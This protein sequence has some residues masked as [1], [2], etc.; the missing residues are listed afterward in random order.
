MLSPADN[1]P[2]DLEQE[3]A[4]RGFLRMVDDLG[5]STERFFSRLYRGLMRKQQGSHGERDP[6]SEQIA[7]LRRE[8]RDLM[9]RI[10][11]MQTA[12]SRLKAVFERISEGVIMQS[13]EGRI[14]LMNDAATKLLGSI[15]AFWDSELGRMFRRVQDA[16]PLA[17]GEEVTPLGEPM[18]VQINDRILGATIAA[19]SAP[20]G[21]PLGTLIVLRDVTREA[22]ADRIKD[23]FVTQITHELRTPL[24]SIKGMSDVLLNAP[25]DKPANRKF[26]EAIARNAAVLDRMIVELLDL[27][28]ISAGSFSIR[29]ESLRLDLLVHDTVK[30]REA[31]IKKSSLQVGVMVADS[32]DLTINGDAQ[33]LLW[34][35]G[36][37]L[38]NAL[39]YTLR[40]GSISIRVGR[41]KKDHVLIEVIDSG[42]GISEYDQAHVFERFYR[43]Q[44][45]TTD[46]KTLDPRGLGQGL[47]IVKAVAEAHGGYAAVSSEIGAGSKFTIGLP[48][49]SH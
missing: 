14:V 8:N 11:R 13:P 33:R 42:V 49:R 7:T 32:P 28:E 22:L 4:I 26:L 23:Q 48:R 31:Q 9:T 18:R 17:E 46:G 2:L 30:A 24:T 38:D 19:V 10:N 40:G 15:K 35:L 34:A 45:K 47:F 29:E 5:T 16:H 27:S 25:P 43:G 36:H 3:G 12:S 39:N 20:D 41:L 37:L 1:T 6:Q 21:L 44:A